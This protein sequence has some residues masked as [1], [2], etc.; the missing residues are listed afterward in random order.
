[1]F[2]MPSRTEPCGLAHIRALRYGAI[3]IVRKTGNLRDTVTEG[4][5]GFVFSGY[6]ADEMT[7]ACFRARDVWKDREAW[8]KIT[9][10]A[11]NANHGWSAPAKKY[12][13]LYKE[14]IA[15]W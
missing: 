2:L 15:L 1:M 13:E 11:M 12:A 4:E 8:A 9:R 6:T 5:N 14:A 3:P 10:R 7:A